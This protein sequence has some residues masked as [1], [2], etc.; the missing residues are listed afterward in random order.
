MN[1]E[2]LEAKYSGAER[3]KYIILLLLLSVSLTFL[4]VSSQAYSHITS[5]KKFLDEQFNS[6]QRFKLI[7]NYVEEDEKVF[8]RSNDN[9]QRLKK[10]F[11]YLDSDENLDYLE[12][13]FQPINFENFIGNN[14]FKYMYE[15]GVNRPEFTLDDKKLTSVKALH[16]N[17]RVIKSFD[18]SLQEG[19]YPT[20][21]E[22]NY[23]SNSKLPIILGAE[24]KGVYNVGDTINIDNVGLFIEGVVVGI[25][26]EDQFVINQ[27]ST[28]FLDRYVLIPSLNFPNL[29]KDK[30]EKGYQLRI[31]LQKVN[32]VIESNYLSANEVQT[33][34]NK[35]SEDAYLKRFTIAGSTN[36]DLNIL[37]LQANE[38]VA[39]A[40]FS[41]F[42]ILI[43]VLAMIT[44][45]FQNE[46]KIRARQYSI[47][48][49]NGA[50]HLSIQI[51]IL[52]R[53][54][55]LFIYGFTVSVFIVFFINGSYRLNPYIIIITLI[56][57]IISTIKPIMFINDI[58]IGQCIRRRT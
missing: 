19:R 37:S 6:I 51:Q 45:V 28:V 32:G 14:T 22:Y 34:V 55:S 27:G 29:P 57:A 46:T 48:I 1:N 54:M 11:S 21:S 52:K 2:S 44:L 36:K 53:I 20:D 9:V 5:S 23:D 15:S 35:Y 8:F 16:Y 50:T 24:Y 10:F 12:I 3:I 39:V 25:L 40:G 58:N 26:K 42:L 18:L 4:T 49:L 17:S 56:T 13:G 31:Y 33:I 47:E 41:G 30:Y 38:L 7:D 43:Y